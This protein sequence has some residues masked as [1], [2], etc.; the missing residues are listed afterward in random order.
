M[1]K[2]ILKIAITSLTILL[3]SSGTLMAQ[4]NHGGQGNGENAQNHTHHPP[5]GGQMKEAGK[6]HI[7]MVVD[8]FLKKDR[9]TFYLFKGKLKPVVNEEITGIITIEY[10]DGSTVTDTLRAGGDNYFVAQLEKPEPFTC[11]VNF[12]V[13]GKLVSGVFT[14]PGLEIKTGG[15]YTCPMHPEIKKESPGTCP[16]CGMTLEK[17]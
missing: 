10:K 11:I 13:K 15:V 12:Q 4:H 1:K 3:I 17:Q 8:L 6:Y 9:L 5:H 2:N 16:K 7:E 14:H